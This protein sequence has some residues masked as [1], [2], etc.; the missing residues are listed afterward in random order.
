MK[1]MSAV[2][3]TGFLAVQTLSTQ[4]ITSAVPFLL[5][6]PNSRASGMGEAGVALADDG[7]ASFW[8]PAGYAFQ[9]G[10]EISLSH[11][12]WLPQFYLSDLWIAH[13]IYKQE[14]QDID[15]TI[16]TGITYLNLGEFNRTENDPTVLE[17]FK[18]YEFALTAGY[19]TK[20]SSDLG[21]GV[22]TRFIYSNIAPFGAGVEKGRGVSSGFSFDVGFL[23]KPVSMFV[24]FTDYDLGDRLNLGLNISNIGPHMAYIDKAQ[25]DPLPMNFRLGFALKLLQSEYN[26]FTLVGDFSKLLI[27]RDSS[28]TTDPF[29]KA[30]FS[31]WYAHSF[32]ETIRQVVTGLGAEYWYGS[33]KLVAL[34]TGYFYEDPRAGNRKFMTFGGGIRFDIYT[35]DFSYISAFEDQHPLGETLR[36]TL[37]IM[38]GDNTP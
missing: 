6:A 28:G 2:V 4:V 8:N 10:S 38:W 24:P 11:A 35:F 25:A 18:G 12:N 27:T 21:I 13:F 14:V 7:W 9:R 36:F 30:F 19:G 33:P 29:Y 32:S 15:G 16:S 31:S 37:G 34:R 26:N 23:Y 22:N 20:L 3:L 17:T 5:I 1:R